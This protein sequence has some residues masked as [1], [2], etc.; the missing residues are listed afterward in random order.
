MTG[1]AVSIAGICNTV[2]MILLRCRGGSCSCSCLSLRIVVVLHVSGMLLLL[3]W[4][5][6]GLLLV[7]P[8]GF[9]PKLMLMRE[10]MLL[11]LLRGQHVE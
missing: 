7:E 6:V 9:V 8:R 3:L 5:L 4:L 10:H 11:L 2:V 1:V